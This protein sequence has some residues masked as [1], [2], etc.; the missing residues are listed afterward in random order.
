MPSDSIQKPVMWKVN[1]PTVY[2]KILN[3]N[4]ILWAKIENVNCWFNAKAFKA[5]EHPSAWEGNIF[6]CD[7]QEW[8]TPNK[9]ATDSSVYTHIH[10]EDAGTFASLIYR[11]GAIKENS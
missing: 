4:S 2:R 1:S 10:L 3:Y 6:S 9:S 5:D 7:L 11:D 8:M